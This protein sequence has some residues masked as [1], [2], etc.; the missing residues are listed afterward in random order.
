M[1]ASAAADAAALQEGAVE[2][3]EDLAGEGSALADLVDIDFFQELAARFLSWV[4]TDVLTLNAALQLALVLA[5]IGPAVLFGPRLKD[6][7]S[8]HLRKQ[9][10]VGIMRRVADATATLATP[11]AAWLTLSIFMGVL[12]GAMGRSDG[13]LSAAQS[14]LAAWIVVRMVT[15][16]IRSEFWSKVAFLVAWPIAALDA[17]GVLG[18]VFDWMRLQT[19]EL[20]ASDPLAGEPAAIISLYDVLRAGLIFAI[21]LVASNFVAGLIIGRVNQTEELNVSFKALVAKILNFVLPIL[22]LLLALAVIGFDLTYLAVFGG[23]AAIGIGL[24]LQRILGNFLAGFTLLAD[25]S[26]KPGDVI[27]VGDTFGWIVEMKSRYVAI[28][29]RDGTEHLIPNST[30]MDEGV[31]NWSHSDGAVRCKAEVG[32]AYDTKDLGLVR[33]I[34]IAAAKDTPRVLPTPAPVCNLVGFGASS[35][36]FHLRFWINDPPNGIENVRSA[37][38]L[39]VWDGF[40][41]A[42][43][44]IPFPQRD[45]HIRSS[46]VSLLR[47]DY[48]EAAE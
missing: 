46:A 7:I 31:I 19:F 39:K 13:F 18:D 48:Q 16:A 8:R 20:T 11:I 2:A 21:F 5:A 17:F 3:A 42:G 32:V 28:R 15:L 34:C 30:F 26:I 29:T 1:L 37:V 40:Q 25:R 23:A 10:P 9:V 45:L 22:A 35:V 33:Q 12:G 24:G 6:F 41:E 4:R 44:E 38:L 36:D 43:I 27:Q 47:D 14:L